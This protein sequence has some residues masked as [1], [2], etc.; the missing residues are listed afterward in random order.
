MKNLDRDSLNFGNG[1]IPR[2]FAK[3]LFPTLSGMTFS[4]L[5]LLTDGIFIGNGIGGDGLAAVNLVMP[6]FTVATAVG[7]MFAVGASVAAAI[8][9]S[10]DNLK[11]A[12]IIV[13]Q[14]FAAVFTSGIVL[15]IVLYAFPDGMLGLMGCSG[16]LMQ[17]CYEYYLWF[18]PC[19][20][21]LMIQL[22]GQFIIRLDGS[23]TYS[24]MVEI[25]PACINIF[26]DWLL[27]F[28][29]GWGLKGAA[30]ATSIGA[31]V[32]AAMSMWYMFF[33]R[34][35]LSFYRLKSTL[36]SIVLTLRNIG[37]MMRIGLSAF[38]GEFSISVVTLV[39][40]YV[41][42]KHLGEDGVA[43][44]SVTCYLIPVVFMVY[45]AISQ[46]AQPI[47][48]YNFGAGN[49]N[50]VKNTF[51]LVVLS[52]LL[53]GIV[54]TALMIIFVR[55]VVSVF[56]SEGSVAYDLCVEGFPIYAAGFVF[57]AVGLTV[58]GY[59]QSVEK[60][61]PATVLTLSRGMALPVAAFLILPEMVGHIG[62]W[63]AVPVAEL[64]TV[65]LI[66][67]FAVAGVFRLRSVHANK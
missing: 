4:V 11:A 16:S 18:I 66:V 53:F 44:Y 50:R 46:S 39:G 63:L 38:I 49:Y 43:A 31:F 7:M 41:F 59:F 51:R 65:V 15:G 47:I 17:M 42:L 10:Q 37:N 22:V 60:S 5:F 27:I 26:L 61:L 23:P 13:T 14:A 32:G 8:H 52:S 20:L 48:S 19:A 58:I 30:L 56:L 28:P 62:I 40:N 34:R 24:M 29:V 55:P 2:M 12:R 64:L 3:M 6:M 21:F 45:S 1:S 36:T 35:S 54:V 33:R 9:M 57:L 67:I 25:I